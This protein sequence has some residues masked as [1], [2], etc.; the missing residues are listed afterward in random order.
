[1]IFTGTAAKI[2]VANT[3]DIGSAVGPI[4]IITTGGLIKFGPGELRIS[5]ATGITGGG[6]TIAQGSVKLLTATALPAGQNVTMQPGSTLDL[7]NFGTPAAPVTTN[8]LAG[9]GTLNIGNGAFQ[10]GTA[11]TAFGGS[12][13]GTG[14]LMKNGTGTLTLNG[15]SP[16]FSG[17]VRITNGTLLLDANVVPGAANPGPL[18]TGT[19]PILLGDPTGANNPSLQFSTNVTRFERDIIVPAGGTGITTAIRATDGIVATVTSNISLQNRT[20]QFSLG[21]NTNAVIGSGAVTFTG[22]ISGSGPGTAGSFAIVY[23]GGYLNLWG[24][25]TFTGD[26]RLFSGNRAFIGIGSDTAFGNPAN[27]IVSNSTFTGGFRADNGP[28]TIPNPMDFQTTG[29]LI[30]YTGV[31]DMN[32][33]GQMTIGTAAR[34]FDVI[35]A[36]ITTFSGNVIGTTGSIIKNGGGT[37][38]LSGNSTY[39][40]GTTVNAGTLLVNSQSGS[41]TGTGAVTV[42]AATLGG[43]GTI[44]GA[45]T[46]NANGRLKPG[47]SPGV[48]TVGGAVT[49]AT[50]SIFAGDIQGTTPGNGTNNHAQLIVTG[51]LTL[52]NPTLG[53]TFAGYTPALTD[54]IEFIR[55]TGGTLTGTFN[56]LPD[57]SIAYSNVLGSGIDYRIWY[58]S[59]PAFGSS[60]VLSP[61]PEPLHILLV[62]G[63]AAIGVRWWRRRQKRQEVTIA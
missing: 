38:V 18:G 23:E 35:S 14:T 1:V 17:D 41:G 44:A 62:C 49:M 63:G 40:G 47:S 5:D 36:G 2:T 25:N 45:V 4:G 27:V 52:N 61:V 28:R 31:N 20:L 42:N 8:A 56:G 53:L 51:G 10:T 30:T 34:T 48:L 13:V 3:L 57:G 37:M 33:T 46:I 32:W 43:N 55:Y 39:A 22:A 54:Q 9:F 58:G 19:T 6:I 12:V 24:N 59:L 11:S 60:I 26:V 50:G 21:T 29:A 16:N 15:N 7:N